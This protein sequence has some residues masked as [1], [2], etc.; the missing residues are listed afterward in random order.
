MTPLSP[1]DI[2]RFYARQ[3]AGECA[4]DVRFTPTTGIQVGHW[5]LCC[6]D[7]SRSIVTVTVVNRHPTLSLVCLPIL[8]LKKGRRVRFTPMLRG[9]P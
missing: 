4:E 3:G 7:T 8:R 9:L 1:G 6:I 2:A 5:F